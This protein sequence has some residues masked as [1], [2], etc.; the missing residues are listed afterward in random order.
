MTTDNHTFLIR[1][2][3]LGVMPVIDLRST[4]IVFIWY[5]LV[6][7]GPLLGGVLADAQHLPHGRCQAGDRH[8]MSA[9]PGTTS[10]WA[11]EVKSQMEILVQ[12]GQEGFADGNKPKRARLRDDNVTAGSGW[13]RRVSKPTR[14]KPQSRRVARIGHEFGP[15]A[16]PPQ[17]YRPAAQLDVTDSG[18]LEC[19]CGL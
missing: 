18:H 10:V 1:K 7:G 5:L 12:S 17:R 13:C 8:S 9:R 6:S 4:A 2:S 14:S 19:S 3:V 11:A 16:D 15:R